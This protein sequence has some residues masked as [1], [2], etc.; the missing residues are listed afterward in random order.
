MGA[1]IRRAEYAD[2]DHL[3]ELHASSWSEL[4]RSSLSKEVLGELDAETMTMLWKKFVFKGGP[5]KQ[6]VAEIDGTIVGFVGVGPG[7]EPESV[8]LTE[9]YFFY[10][11][12]SARKS[13][14]GTA[15][16]EQ[17][18]ADYLWVWE[19]LKKTRKYYDKRGYKPE[20]VRATRGVGTKSRASKMFGAYLTEFRLM[21]P[22]KTAQA[23]DAA[24]GAQTEFA[25]S[26]GLGSL[27]D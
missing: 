23:A 9:L 24:T 18:D 11:A 19:G 20:I 5:Y 10:V 14:A 8:D 22:L 3:G 4:Y 15:L 16:L 27:D 2:V 7:R 13:G 1:T 25:G 26:V 6:W 17:A 12:P 21:R